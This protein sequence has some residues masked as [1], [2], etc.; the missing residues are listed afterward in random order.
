MF[1][2][3]SACRKDKQIFCK[4]SLV[5]SDFDSLLIKILICGITVLTSSISKKYNISYNLYIDDHDR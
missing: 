3:A 5:S 4:A 2:W 1:S